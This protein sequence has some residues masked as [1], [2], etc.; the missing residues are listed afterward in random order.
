MRSRSRKPIGTALAGG[1]VVLMM[2]MAVASAAN[3]G[4]N[5]V[6][7]RW[8]EPARFG[9]VALMV[10][11][12][13]MTTVVTAGLQIATAAIVARSDDG[14]GTTV[15]A[16]RWSATYYATGAGV[17]L[18]VAADPVASMLQVG[19]PRLLVV[20]AVGLPLHI[21]LG[22]ERGRIQ[23]GLALGRLAA[24][25]VVESATRFAV[26]LALV[27]IGLGELGAT[28]G[29]NLGFVAAL[30]AVGHPGLASVPARLPEA[31][32][33][34]LRVACRNVG[35]L[36]LGTAIINNA[37][38]ICSKW[39]LSPADAG[40]YAAVALVGRAIFFVAWSLQQALVPVAARL[41]SDDTS[42]ARLLAGAAGFTAALAGSLAAAAWAF[43]D[44]IVRLAFGADY[45]PVADQLGR[46]AVATALFAVASTI[47]TLD[48]ARD[49]NDTALVVLAGAVVQT[50]ALTRAGSSLSALVTIQMWSMALL[51]AAVFSIRTAALLKRPA[52][53]VDVRAE[54]IPA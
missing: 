18:A 47:A 13:M 28:I 42:E 29:L 17:V 7:G 36:M 41:R 23:G 10:T 37:D 45:L 22:V 2:A 30:G 51:V 54:G 3:Y 26:T 46:Y 53:R 11:L 1:G 33:A 16:L 40:R 48:T 49:R 12:M 24:T 27:A 34:E 5:I 9:D 8:L 19:D 15:A 43:D 52:V 50:I 44:R 4:I 32:K 14:A 31:Q 39:L 38:V 6:L 21:R 35:V 25:F 20:M